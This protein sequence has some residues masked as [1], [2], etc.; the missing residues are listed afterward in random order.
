LEIAGNKGVR[1]IMT[2]L[3]I[4]ASKDLS[5]KE[6]IIDQSLENSPP[7]LAKFKSR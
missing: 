3:V 6:P 1:Q 2:K 5:Y 7:I 4:L